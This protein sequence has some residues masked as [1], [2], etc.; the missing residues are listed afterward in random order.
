MRRCA[1]RLALQYL[2]LELGFYL[3]SMASD[4]LSILSSLN[5]ALDT[6]SLL[7][8][9]DLR[10]PRGVGEQRVSGHLFSEVYHI[11]LLGREG[12]GVYGFRVYAS[13]W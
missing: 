4:S 10:L 9:A 13:F 3:V 2:C 7:S 11:V 6:P 12:T 1:V 8:Q 5:S